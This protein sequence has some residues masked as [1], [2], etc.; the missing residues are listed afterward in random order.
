MHC[1]G[2]IPARYKSSRFPGK[3]LAL[4][5]NKPMIQHVFER[6]RDAKTLEQVYIATDDPRIRDAAMEFTEN[7]IMTSPEHQSGTDRIAEAVSGMDAELVVNIQG[8]EPLIR[9]RVID[10]AVKPLL[11][12]NDIEMGTLAC[13]LPA[14]EENNTN[15]VKV[16]FDT[17]HRALYF[18][19]ATIPYHRTGADTPEFWQHIGLYVYRSDFLHS[20]TEYPPTPLER[21]ERLEQLRALEHGH[22]IH[23]ELTDYTSIGVDTET[24]LEHVRTIYETEDQ[25]L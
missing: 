6:S 2:V 16:V 7:V 20:F 19:R 14:G 8:D 12:S 13:P 9:S 22:Y 25:I 15:I 17:N 3:P 18:S 4:I 11:E 5:A 10:S 24:D 23:V 21:K 1:I